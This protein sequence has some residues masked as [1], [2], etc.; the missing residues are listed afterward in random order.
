M[1]QV[2]WFLPKGG[3]QRPRDY[4]RQRT[5]MQSWPVRDSASC[6]ARPRPTGVATGGI[7]GHTN[8]F[9]VGAYG[10]WRAGCWSTIAAPDCARVVLRRRRDS[11]YGGS[12]SPFLT[13]AFSALTGSA[14]GHKSPPF[15][16]LALEPG[17]SLRGSVS[18]RSIVSVAGA[19]AAL[20]PVAPA[21]KRGDTPPVLHLYGLADAAGRRGQYAVASTSRA[22]PRQQV[23]RRVA[24]PSSALR[25]RGAKA[26][27]CPTP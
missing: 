1:A 19:A 23:R 27:G 14:W 21:A 11:D 3:G 20:R 15:N 10:T 26:N 13:S 22:R 7:R 12:G 16:G 17:I 9:G 25:A 6:A 5:E 2:D 24:A 18:G 4:Y 8:L